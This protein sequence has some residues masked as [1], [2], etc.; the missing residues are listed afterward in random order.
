M[1]ERHGVLC[2][3]FSNS[4][5]TGLTAPR[6][7]DDVIV[8][9]DEKVVSEHVLGA[10]DDIQNFVREFI[11]KRKATDYLRVGVVNFG[12]FEKSDIS[13]Y[14]KLF[15]QVILNDNA[16]SGVLKSRG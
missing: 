11:E 2:R 15:T 12:R 1:L 9:M 13:A 8:R 14:K 4:V 7:H 3:T 10:N 6:G 16:I 5:L